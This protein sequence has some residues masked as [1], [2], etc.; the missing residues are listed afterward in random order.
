[1]RESMLPSHATPASDTRATDERPYLLE[2]VGEAAVVQL[3]ADGFDALSLNEK[4]LAWHLYQAA[5]AGRD[6]YYDQR[7]AHNLVMRD[8]L[9]AVIRFPGGTDAESLA[10][11]TRYTKLFW[12]NTGPYNNLTARK[13]VLECDP[14]ALASAVRH[15]QASGAVLP[16]SPGEDVEA[17]LARLQPLFFDRAVDP[18]VTSKTPGPGKDILQESANNLYADVSMADLEGFV[19]Q[20]P[21][22]SRLVKR[23]GVAAGRG[24]SN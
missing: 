17:L 22:N 3:Y 7:Y 10:A 16:L 5:L 19:E 8:V 23:D 6:I 24:L 2:R 15:A 12:I 14:D 21:L 1:M 11:I 9:E 20:H 13:F 4:R 18:I